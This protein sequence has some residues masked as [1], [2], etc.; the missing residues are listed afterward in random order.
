[1]VDTT[2]S[3]IDASRLAAQ[4]RRRLAALVAADAALLDELHADDFVLVNPGGG[5]WDKA[6]YLGGIT[7]GSID[8]RRFEP[9]TPIQV[10]ADGGVAVVRYR[11]AIEIAVDGGPY[12]SLTAWHLDCYRHDEPTGRWRCVWSQATRTDD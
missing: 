7:D 2:G 11:S 10:L 9:V 8:Y 1:M 4:E 6:F 3:T 5:V 12:V